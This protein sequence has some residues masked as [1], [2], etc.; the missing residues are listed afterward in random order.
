MQFEN[1]TCANLTVTHAALEPQ[2]TFDIFGTKGSIHVPVL[3]KGEIR[4]RT[5]NG[6]YTEFYPPAPNVHQPLIEDFTKAVLTNR[7]PRVN[8]QIGKMVAI[9]EEQIY[10]GYSL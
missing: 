8:G 1:G 6:E 2:D 5:E 7:E 10:K 4:I 3:N 9:L